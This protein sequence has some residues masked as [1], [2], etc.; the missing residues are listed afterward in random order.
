MA[1]LYIAAEIVEKGSV[2]LWLGAP[3]YCNEYAKF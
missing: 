3:L 2:D 1:P